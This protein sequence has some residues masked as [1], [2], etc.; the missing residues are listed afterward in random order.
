MVKYRVEIQHLTGNRLVE[1]TTVKADNSYEAINT[2]IHKLYDKK[3]SFFRDSGLSFGFY[4]QLIKSLPTG[5][6]VCI[7]DRVRIDVYQVDI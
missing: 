1:M 4:G 3:T 5:G 2:A 7:T 6:Y